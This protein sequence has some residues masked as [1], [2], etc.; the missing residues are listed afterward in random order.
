[1]PSIRIPCPIVHHRTFGDIFY[2]GLKVDVRLADGRYQAF[3][4]ILD[5]GADCTMVPRYMA[6]LVGF[7][8]PSQPNES[9]SGISNEVMP[10]FAGEMQ[11]QIQTEQFG[12][13][14]LYMESNRVPFLL[15][16][17][18]F[19]SLYN[20]QFNGRDCCIILTKLN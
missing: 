1:M 14:C 6:N 3:E 17:L 20:V 12:I 10:A 2:P 9:V 7:Q 18:D 13:R 15:G 4:F 8:L 16:R 5:S 19:F 11:L